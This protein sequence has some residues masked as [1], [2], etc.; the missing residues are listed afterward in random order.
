MPEFKKGIFKPQFK[1]N[2]KVKFKTKE[3]VVLP[4]NI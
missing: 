4:I 2:E 1:E 3:I